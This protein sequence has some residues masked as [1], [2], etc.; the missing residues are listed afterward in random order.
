MRQQRP[1]RERGFTSAVFHSAGFTLVELLVVIG[2]IALLISI[3]LP[4]LS[5]ARETA[6]TV[7]CAS[8][9]R[10]VGQ[11][12]A[13]YLANNKGTFPA[14]YIYA[15]M[16]IVNGVQKPFAADQGYI[17]WSSFLYKSSRGTS[18]PN[19]YKSSSGWEMFQCP[20]I[21]KGGLPPTNTTLENLDGNQK[22]DDGNVVDQQA[23]RCAYTVNEAICPR[24]KFVIGFQNA[25]R[26][27]QFVRTIKNSAG[28]VLAT[29]W[30]PNWRIVSD[31]GRSD[32]AATVCKSH[33]PI[34]GF[35]GM[36][37]ELNMEQVAPDPF[38][39]R[40][41]YRRAKVSDLGGDPQAGGAFTTRLDWVGRN[42]GK[43]VLKNGFDERKSNFLY[44]DGHVETKG[45]KE[46]ISPKFEW[47]ER[48]YT[49]N[50]NGDMAPP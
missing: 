46:T 25:A 37:G 2:I 38:G 30:N 6:N 24:N 49:L 45:I 42:H 32:P 22:N 1:R 50:P 3:L 36:T 12:M 48:F 18:D 9:L 13:Q 5:R 19:V 10:S 34:H 27:Y 21:E 16:Q 11:G 39:G 14:A 41:S 15:G 28:T 43:K 17:H 44:V 29:E 26:P 4:A 35:V 40:P 47:G 31:A 20:S 23:P 7:K 33:R 8:N